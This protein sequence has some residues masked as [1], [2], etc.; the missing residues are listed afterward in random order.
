MNVVVCAKVVPV[1]SVTTHIDPVTKRMVRQG[2]NQELDPQAAKAVEEGLRVTERQGGEVTVVVM[3]S[4]DAT[5]GIRSA[6]AMGAAGAIHISDPALAGSDALGTAKALAA[7]IRKV[8]FDL[9]LCA[10]ESSDAYTG[11]VPGQLA[12]LLGIPALTFAISLSVD[13]NV[14]TIKRQ[15]EGGYD[16]V[17]A[18]LPALVTVTTGINEP[19]YPTLKGI[20]SAKK[21]PIQRYAVVDLGLAPHDVGEAGARERVL[22]V[23]RPPPRP[24]G[25]VITDQGDAG[26]QIADFLADLKFV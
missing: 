8:A 23:G 17:C 6:L 9:V 2:V 21:R 22:T 18:E 25:R 26:K 3:G 12:Q 19:R 4:E 20:M 15:S 16:V 5:V 11:L 1:S 10:T 7:A 13:G 24:P 14:A